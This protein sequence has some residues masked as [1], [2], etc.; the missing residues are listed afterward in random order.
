MIDR[1]RGLD[2]NLFIVFDALLHHGS[3]SRAALTLGRSQSAI[4]HALNRLRD[5]YGDELFIKTHDGMMPTERARALEE[6]VTAFV[7]HAEH[8]LRRNVPFDPA[9]TV[10]R[11]TLALSD[12]GELATLPSLLGPLRAEAPHLTLQVIGSWGDSLEAH[13]AEGTVDLVI[14]GPLRLSANIQQQKLFEHEFTVIVSR[15]CPIEGEISLE[16]FGALEEIAVR[17]ASAYRHTF[18]AV[19]E[20][21]GFKRR[22]VVETEHSLVVPHMVGS[23]P[24]FVAIVP[25][26]LAD[27]YRESCRLKLLRPTFDVPKIEIIQYFHRRVKNDPFSVWLRGL[28]RRR[29]QQ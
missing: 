28:I 4:S 25:M 27:I 29:L 5:H 20:R 10:R 9:T 11:V 26:G 12:T 22:P 23:G 14:S 6:A 13:L 7:D 18:D 21:Q 3:V 2:L 16:Q 19:L 1:Y 8:A 24:T 15:D 17:P